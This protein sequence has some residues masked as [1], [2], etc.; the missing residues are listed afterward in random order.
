MRPRACIAASP[1]GTQRRPPGLGFG[2]TEKIVTALRSLTATC[3]L[4]NGSLSTESFLG[5]RSESREPASLVALLHEV[6]FSVHP[7]SS[8]L[9]LLAH[10]PSHPATS[11]VSC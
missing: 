3:D 1:R 6:A 5:V 9:A 8:V 4:G 10:H 7:V 2:I 11:A